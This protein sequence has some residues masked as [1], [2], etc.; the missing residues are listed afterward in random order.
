MQIAII[1]LSDIHLKDY[2]TGISDI[3][4]IT[5]KREKIIKA[6]QNKILD[7]DHVFIVL[8]GDI[9]FSGKS[10]EYEIAKDFILNVATELSTYSGKKIS[11]IG[12][13]GNHD[14]NFSPNQK[15]RELILSGLESQN[16]ADLDESIIQQ[17]CTPQVEYFNFQSDLFFKDSRVILSHQLLNIVEYQISDFNIVF[18]CFNTSWVS[19]KDEKEGRMAFPITLFPSEVFYNPASI[20][21]NIIHHPLNWQSKSSHRDFRRFLNLN[22]DITLSGHEHETDMTKMSDSSN[23]TNIYIESAALQDTENANKSFFNIVSI[24]LDNNEIK[25]NQYSYSNG[26]Y[27][28]TEILSPSQLLEVT[29]KT[30]IDHP[31]NFHFNNYL[32]SLSAQFLHKRAEKLSIDDLYVS[33]FL[34]TTNDETEKIEIVS[35]DKI[36]TSDKTDKI[37]F[38]G[39]EI[40]GKTT[41]C[42]K[43]FREFH[44]KGMLPVLIRGSELKK[45]TFDY[46][47]SDL[48][49]RN[50]FDQ[51]HSNSLKNFEE[52]DKEKLIIIIDDFNACELTESHRKKL[53]AS[54]NKHFT[55]VVFTSNSLLYFNPVTKGDKEFEEYQVYHL[56]EFSYELRYEVIQKWNALEELELSGN[57]LLR[58]N[59]TY[60]QLVKVYLGKNYLPQ[61]PFVIIT[62]LQSI[63]H[64]GSA[65]HGFSY[66]YKYLIE[67]SLKRSIRKA[68]DLQFYHHFLMFYCFFLFEERFRKLEKGSFE[69]LFKDYT[70]QKKVTIP[71]KDALG[72]LI[73]AKILRAEGDFISITYNYIYYYYVASYIA[74]NIDNRETQSLVK[75]LVDRLYVDEY[76]SIIIFLTQI[77]SNDYVINTIKDNVESHFKEFSPATLSSDIKQIDDLM[78]KLPDELELDEASIEERRSREI[79]KRNDAERLEMEAENDY[80]SKDYSLDEDISN[81]SILN[82][83]IRGIKTFEIFGQIIKK[84]WGAYDGDKKEIYVNSTFELALRVLSAYFNLII[85]S[86]KDLVDLIYYVA[87]K[88][89]LTEKSDIEKLAKT[90][91][92]HYAYIA[93]HGI[94][95]RVS[96]SISHYQLKS[97]FN[98]VVEKHP[99]NSYKLIRLSIMM[100]HFGNLP[101]DEIYNLVNK[102]KEFNRYYMTRTLL[103]NFVYQYLHLYD[104]PYDERNKLGSIIGIKMKEQ[105]A[106]Q[107]ASEEKK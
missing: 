34:R 59:E 77:S 87:D 67:E 75:K 65:E 60:D 20:K 44:N 92:F 26:H 19:R 23:K 104:V 66:Y 47:F 7:F 56:L 71:F 73:K 69:R 45:S 11:L 82:K 12:I 42:K 57:E 105:R 89:Q 41:I 8:S 99:V 43:I 68:D 28:P 79:K 88:K 96:N 70:A 39:E 93:A 38:I 2:V 10:T 103:Q 52:I 95:K 13:P 36:I 61:Y 64:S 78:K 107:G 74:A 46:F 22:G 51:Y 98:E 4:P 76:S 101:N 33:P 106:I 54:I 27:T 102:D 94:I 9:A 5:R 80:L 72:Q 32:D 62:A 63:D 81:L 1:H 83:L 18:N 85:K 15:T 100:D 53:I 91:I 86:E 21:I 14:C 40:S 35:F 55:N 97:T 49:K 30:K 48:I 29:K 31:L 6:I 24:N 37:I 50:F 16:F 90:L 25:A 84:N 17:C 3:N 58:K